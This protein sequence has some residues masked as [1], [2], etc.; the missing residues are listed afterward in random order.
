ME[1]NKYFHANEPFKDYSNSNNDPVIVRGRVII[2]A[3]G[4]LTDPN[5]K[6]AEKLTNTAEGR[7]HNRGD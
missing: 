7:N 3:A 1:W 5:E 4:L 6:T 2:S